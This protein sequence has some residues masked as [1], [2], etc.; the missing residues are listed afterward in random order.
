MKPLGY[1]VDQIPPIQALES[2]YGS[3]LE[4]LS[5]NDKLGI[6]AVLSAWLAND[7]NDYD[8]GAAIRDIARSMAL[9]DEVHHAIA[10]LEEIQPKYAVDLMKALTQFLSEQF[11]VGAYQ[12]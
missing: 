8:L 7:D 10:M 3:Y 1:Y 6:N 11:R 9:S 4:R 2:Y 5:A 12:S